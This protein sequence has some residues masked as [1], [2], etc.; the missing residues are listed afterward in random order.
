MSL[1]WFVRTS[2]TTKGMLLLINYIRLN[3]MP[4]PGH[5]VSQSGGMRVYYIRPKTGV[6]IETELQ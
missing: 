5:S 4:V 1:I 3:E 6:A 2:Q